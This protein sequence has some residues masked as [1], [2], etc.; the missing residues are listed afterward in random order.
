M[1][2]KKTILPKSKID[3]INNRLS[4]LSED[5]EEIR[6]KTQSVNSKLIQ[7]FHEINLKPSHNSKK[8]Q[9]AN[10]CKYYCPNCK[11]ELDIHNFEVINKKAD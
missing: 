1:I 11:Q 2:D 7:L 10:K 9:S 6:F 5:I 4:K 3:I 8:N